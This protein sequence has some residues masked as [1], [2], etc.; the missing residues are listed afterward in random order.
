VNSILLG[1]GLGRMGM[2][3][4]KLG[5]ESVGHVSKLVSIDESC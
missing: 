3:Q 1:L 4:N 5:K 2:K